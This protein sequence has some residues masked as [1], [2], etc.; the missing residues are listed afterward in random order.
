[1]ATS[2]QSDTA[3]QVKLA[4]EAFLYGY[5]LVYCLREIA[6]FP[7]GP[8]LVG[9]QALPYNTFGYARRLLGPDAHFVSPNNDTLYL[10]AMCDVRQGP[11]VLHVPETDDRYYVLQF[12]DAWTNNFAYI[13]RRATGTAEAHYVLAAHDYQGD[14]PDGMRVVR[15]PSGVFVIAGR[16][17]V[18]GEADLPAVHA[19]QDQFTLTPLSVV[20]GGAAPGPMAGVP[21]ADGRVGQD[22]RWWEEFRVALAAFPPPAA[23]APFLA[24]CQQMGLTSAESPYVDP[25]PTLAQ[26]LVAGQQ[27]AQDKLEE[28]IQT[29]ARPVNGWQ[30]TLHIFDYNDDYF[31]IGTL[32]DP[33]WRIPDRK[34]AYVTRTVAARA[35]LW[36]NHGYEANYQLVYVDGDNQPLS[37]EHRYELHLPAPPPV[38]AFWSLTMYDAHEFYLVE[39]ALH[40]Y[41]IGD[42]TP[43][44]AYGADGS[45]TIYLQK[46]SPGADKEANWLPTPQQGGFRPIMRMYQPKQ[47]ILD[48]SYLL[49]AIQRVE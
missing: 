25:D 2:T 10:M 47:P 24:I 20:R 35:G 37:S 33:Q 28:L 49:P 5:P 32:T 8:N 18:D 26:I 39:N 38:D 1:M 41:S 44:L 34:I 42:R 16:I 22:L 21:Q 17:A 19:L 3:E 9:P 4:A 7:A 11:L 13:G 43:G 29:A 36:G 6:K 27:A 23:D 48:G 14:A 12:V 45:L 31:E 40:R 30:N 15:A 46:D